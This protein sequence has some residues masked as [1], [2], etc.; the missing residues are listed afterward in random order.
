MFL[1]KVRRILN[2]NLNLAGIFDIYRRVP[3]LSASS[4]YGNSAD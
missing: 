2:T 1:D 3:A 4:K